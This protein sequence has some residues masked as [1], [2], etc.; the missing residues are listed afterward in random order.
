MMKAEADGGQDITYVT[1]TRSRSNNICV[2]DDVFDIG[3]HLQQN[4]SFLFFSP[5]SIPHLH[6][7]PTTKDPRGVSRGK[8]L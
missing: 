8:R 5:Q 1:A 6:S 3:P 2:E 4:C 7:S